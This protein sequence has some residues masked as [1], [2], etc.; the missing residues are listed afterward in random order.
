MGLT[1]REAEVLVWVVQGKQNEDIGC[2][3]EI[4]KQ[5]VR[6]HVENILG[7]LCC[8]TRGAAAMLAMSTLTERTYGVSF[9]LS[10]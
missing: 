2:I 8:E 6:K 4:S 5:T 1:H 9:D 10:F 7:K 3:L